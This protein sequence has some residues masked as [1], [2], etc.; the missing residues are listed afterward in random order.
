MR[1]KADLLLRHHLAYA[2]AHPDEYKEFKTIADHILYY[3]RSELGM[4]KSEAKRVLEAFS[5]T[6]VYLKDIQSYDN[7]NMYL[8]K[9]ANAVN[10]AVYAVF[11]QGYLADR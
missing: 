7:P 9:P 10:F 2:A 11:V 4:S 8:R 3:F 1:I 5:S 6:T